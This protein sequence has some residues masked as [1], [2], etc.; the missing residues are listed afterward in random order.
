MCEVRSS[1]GSP[2]DTSSR[3][4]IAITA[5]SNN[6]RVL[7]PLIPYRSAIGNAPLERWDL[8]NQPYTQINPTRRT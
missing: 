5:I 6:A 2:P 7:E 4:K 8:Y 3:T 1:T